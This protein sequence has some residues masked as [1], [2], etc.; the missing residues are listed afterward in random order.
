VALA[1]DQRAASSSE[2]ASFADPYR[3][4]RA[5]GEAAQGPGLA[6]HPHPLVERP[7][8]GRKASDDQPGHTHAGGTTPE[9]L[10]ARI[11]HDVPALLKEMGAEISGDLELPEAPSDAE[12]LQQFAK[13][14]KLFA[15]KQITVEFMNNGDFRSAF[16]EECTALGLEMG[17]SVV[18][19]ATLSTGDHFS[20]FGERD[21]AL[22]LCKLPK[23]VRVPVRAVTA[24]GV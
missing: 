21:V 18:T 1:P 17:A 8:R 20:I 24:F 7:C 22:A 23:K 3:A 10:R 14:P 16:A 19:R 13:L 4:G 2:R 11:L 9:D 5:G 15:G 6:T 12:V